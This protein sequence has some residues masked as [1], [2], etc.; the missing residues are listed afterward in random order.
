M[1]KVINAMNEILEDFIDMADAMRLEEAKVRG[2]VRPLTA[3]EVSKA[4]TD[5]GHRHVIVGA[6]A[7][8]HHSSEARSTSDV[9]VVSEDPEKA[10]HVLSK[11][12]HG[13]TVRQHDGISVWRVEVPHP[14]KPGETLELADIASPE[15]ARFR[16]A[17]DS[18]VKTNSGIPVVSHDH[19]V[20]M[21]Y[22]AYRS[23]R[24]G[25]RRKAKWMSDRLDL[26]NLVADRPV[27]AYRVAQHI[28]GMMLHGKDHPL[29]PKEWLYDYDNFVKNGVEFPEP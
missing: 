23:R 14:A 20:A 18:A 22:M 5:S 4:L 8:V 17:L 27:N 3:K 29:L 28:R 11:L 7:V 15:H 6:H 13:A 16:G 19:L 1:N 26:H 24:S 10:A 9:D 25:G 21:K 2:I 12:R